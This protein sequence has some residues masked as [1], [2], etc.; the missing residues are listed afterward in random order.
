MILELIQQLAWTQNT[1]TEFLSILFIW[2]FAGSYTIR[3]AYRDYFKR[4]RWF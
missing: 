2:A 1:F 4:G 3:T